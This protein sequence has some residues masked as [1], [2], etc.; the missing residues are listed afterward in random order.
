MGVQVNNPLSLEESNPWKS[1]FEDLELRRMIRQ[2]VQRTW[3]V[4]EL[5]ESCRITLTTNDAAFPTY[6]TFAS[7]RR[8][9][10]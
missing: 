4:S 10:R 7:P 8:T 6:R 3:V 5:R 9:I 2:D 1:W